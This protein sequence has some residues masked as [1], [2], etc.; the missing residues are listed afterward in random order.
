[1][2]TVNIVYVDDNIDNH[3]SE[4]LSS[5]Y[6]YDGVELIYDER[7]FTSNDSYESLL[8]DEKIRVADIIIIDSVLFENS[9]SNHGCLAGEEFEIITKKFFPY[10]EVLVVTQNDDVDDDLKIIRKYDSSTKQDKNEYFDN[11]W[12]PSLDDKIHKALVYRKLLDKIATKNYVEK[13]SLEK[14][15]KS[16]IGDDSYD[17]LTVEDV[18]KLIE[19]FEGLKKKYE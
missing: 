19:T 17:E 6:R 4:Y 13:Y 15:Q 10:K 7:K 12:K 2:K 16:L 9:N 14:M 11:E 1:M 3:I 18:D 5:R 8:V